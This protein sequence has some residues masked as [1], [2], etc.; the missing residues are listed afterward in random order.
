MKLPKLISILIMAFAPVFTVFAQPGKQDPE[1]ARILK[2]DPTRAGVQMNCYEFGP[3][4]DTKAPKG[5]KPFYISHYG[6]HGARSNWGGP[7]YKALIE[8]LSKAKEQGILTASGDSLLDEVTEV[9][10][11]HNEMS[12]RLT[13]KGCEEHQKLAERMY[14]RY[15]KVF[16]R[17]GTT[18]R[19]ISSNV[20][21]CLVSMAAFTSKLSAIDPK[22]EMSWDTGETY[23]KYINNGPTEEI[24]KGV[25][26]RVDS[27]NASYH[28]DTT[29]IID[30]LFTDPVAAKVLVP[31]VEKFELDVIEAGV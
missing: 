18:I 28:V 3:L 23:Q 15:K 14:G 16:K 10:R 21:R 2:E 29:A 9:N 4:H 31:D 1:I 30:L 8:V 19:A 17:K 24:W 20:P 11:I 7:Q 5:Y 26:R 13:R 12:G 22:L 6:R 25:Y 27:L